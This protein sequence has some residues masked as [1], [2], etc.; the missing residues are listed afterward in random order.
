M[1]LS[2]G[3]FWYQ[4]NE[5]V[6]EDNPDTLRAEWFPIGVKI[7]PVTAKYLIDYT[8]MVG[9]RVEGEQETYIE[10]QLRLYAPIYSWD[11]LSLS[12][13]ARITLHAEDEYNG[14]KGYAAYKDFGRNRLYLKANYAV[15]EN[16]GVYVQYAYELRDREARDNYKDTVYN[17]DYQALIF[18]WNYKF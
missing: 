1:F 18:G 10:H 11:K 12:T 7:G 14:T 4:V 17:D 9:G 16:L 3:D 2:S 13:E 15:S 5:A 8:E 6:K